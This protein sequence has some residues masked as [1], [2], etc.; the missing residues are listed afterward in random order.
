[1]QFTDLMRPSL[2]NLYEKRIKGENH[3]RRFAYDIYQ[4]SLNKGTSMLK[5]DD[6][7]EIYLAYYFGLH[8][9]K[10]YNSFTE[11]NFQKYGVDTINLVDWGSGAAVGSLAF[12]NEFW[13]KVN[14]EAITL[15]EPSAAAIKR[16]K[17]YIDDTWDEQIAYPTVQVINQSFEKLA[18]RDLLIT[19]GATNLHIFS[20]ILD[21]E[22]IDIE[23]L[24]NLISAT[25][26]GWNYFLCV[27]SVA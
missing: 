27:S 17:Q 11:I 15:I 10:L 19:N 6:E 23:S 3:N 20:N 22:S 4:K 25:Q 26:I 16:G 13:G 21:I 14:I 2:L 12:I 8:F 7:V 5:T 24:C 9:C 18:K 1:M